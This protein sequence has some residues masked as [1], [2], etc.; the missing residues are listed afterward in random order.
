MSEELAIKRVYFVRHGETHCNVANLVQPPD[1]PLNENGLMQAARVA[2]RARNLTFQKLI[3][4]DYPRAQQTA[5]AIA[6]AVGMSVETS[7]LFR[8]FLGPSQFFRLPNSTDEFTTFLQQQR[9]HRDDPA[10]HFA[11]EENYHDVSARATEAWRLLESQDC[12]DV[13]VVTHGLFLRLLVMQMVL[14]D[15][16]TPDL[17]YGTAGSMKMSNTGITVCLREHDRWR[18]LTWN[19]HAHF[20]E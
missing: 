2:E 14:G 15:A 16:L 7:P 17:W 5:A 4:S 19:D 1:D 13:L 12:A 8:E 10:W 18:L 11:D 20:A 9:E 6:G 3:A